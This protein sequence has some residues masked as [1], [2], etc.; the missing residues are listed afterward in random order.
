M[1]DWQ[2]YPLL[3]SVDGR[4]ICGIYALVNIING[5]FYVGQSVHVRRRCRNHF[6]NLRSE[7]YTTTN[8]HLQSAFD[9]YGEQVF[10]SVL[11]EGGLAR[12]VMVLNAAEKK[13]IDAL[14]SADRLFGYNLKKLSEK[15]THVYPAESI[16]RM[17]AKL[18]GRV[19]PESVREKLRKA[20]KGRH[21]AGYGA[22]MPQ[23]IKDKISQAR[24][25][26]CLGIVFS[27][28][29]KANISKALAGKTL[30]DEHRKA[31]SD[32]HKQPHYKFNKKV[33]QLDFDGNILG[34]FYSQSEA[35][36]TVG[37]CKP[38]NISRC[39]NGEQKTAGGYKW[40]MAA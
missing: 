26:K 35:A 16:E 7:K 1:S 13:W 27:D 8:P 21:L 32:G 29:R 34:E 3:S 18:K 39:C 37:T 25:G 15:L 38:S 5:K 4:Y 2:Q 9:H 24:K 12:D 22:V 6:S 28:E 20:N 40:K 23:A 10:V 30:S 36:R 17:R 19:I 33:I 11:L 31:C 14:Q